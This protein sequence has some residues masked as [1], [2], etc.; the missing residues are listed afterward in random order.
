MAY[1]NI[2]TRWIVKQDD[3]IVVVE[4][5]RRPADVLDIFVET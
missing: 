5:T 3:T 4:D 1:K 2:G